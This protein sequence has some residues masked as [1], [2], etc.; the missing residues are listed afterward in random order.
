M[1]DLS[2]VSSLL[3]L[4]ELQSRFSALVVAGRLDIEGKSH[5]PVFLYGDRF[6]CMALSFLALHQASQ[7]DPGDGGILND[8]PEPD[9]PSPELLKARADVVRAFDEALRRHTKPGN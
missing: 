1:I 5:E 9:V 2:N 4:R 8:R 3:L 7:G 6:D